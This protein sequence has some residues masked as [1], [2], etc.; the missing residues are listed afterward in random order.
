MGVRSRRAFVMF[1]M[2]LRRTGEP[3]PRAT[4]R[5]GCKSRFFAA[6]MGTRPGFAQRLHSNAGRCRAHVAWR[7]HAS[8]PV[9]I[10]C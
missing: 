5:Y 10:G 6:C 1:R 2:N 9:V 8:A 7:C 3:S 4:V